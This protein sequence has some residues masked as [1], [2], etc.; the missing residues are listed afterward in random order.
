MISLISIEVNGHVWL[1]WG[2][3]FVKLILMVWAAS[4]PKIF[5][6]NMSGENHLSAWSHV[7]RIDCPNRPLQLLRGLVT[8]KSYNFKKIKEVIYSVFNFWRDTRHQ[9]L[10]IW[11]FP[12]YGQLCVRRC[13]SLTGFGS[14]G[15][16]LSFFLC[17]LRQL[18]LHSVQ[19]VTRGLPCSHY[20][21][22][23]CCTTIPWTK[24]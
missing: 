5:I 9:R 8:S 15:V 24:L 3:R 16:E 4:T 6:R 12:K 13:S 23:E 21:Y 20:V 11:L 17:I 1:W 19:H 10:R 2:F 18:C 14:L 22:W 7:R